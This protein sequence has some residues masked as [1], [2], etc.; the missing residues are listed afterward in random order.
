[1]ALEVIIAY[2]YGC[3]LFKH[4]ICGSQPEVPN[5]MPDSSDPLPPEF[6]AIPRCPLVPTVVEVTTDEVDLIESTK[7]LEENAS[8][9]DQS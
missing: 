8:I 3:N 1:M 9:G 2:D 4:N 7:D 6:F 5:D